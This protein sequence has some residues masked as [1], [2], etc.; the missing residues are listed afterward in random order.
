MKGLCLLC[1]L[2]NTQQQLRV[3]AVSAG[4]CIVPIV[5]STN[6]P[7]FSWCNSTLEARR[8]RRGLRSP[9]LG[10]VDEKWSHTKDVVG[11]D[12]PAA[13]Q[14]SRARKYFG[15]RTMVFELLYEPFKKRKHCVQHQ[16]KWVI[17]CH[18]RT[19]HHAACFYLRWKAPL[20]LGKK[21][22]YGYMF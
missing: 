8:V 3:H 2:Y 1:Q 18:T 12:R 14:H 19:L 21:L 20:Y 16:Q 6:L 15:I 5:H 7:V 17:L 9:L 4:G 10:L 13:R 22:I 11:H